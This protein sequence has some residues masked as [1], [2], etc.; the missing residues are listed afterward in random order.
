[1]V[2]GLD[3]PFFGRQR[4]CTEFSR[5]E[6]AKEINTKENHGPSFGWSVRDVQGKK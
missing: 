5:F 2:K 3:G 1:M 4:S 6:K